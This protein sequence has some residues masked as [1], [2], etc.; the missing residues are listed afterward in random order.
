MTTLN[1]INEALGEF[2]QQYALAKE[3][4]KRVINMVKT[5]DTHI[6]FAPSTDNKFKMVQIEID[7]SE[8]DKD[9]KYLID[10]RPT[11][12]VFDGVNDDTVAL[13]F[14]IARNDVLKQTYDKLEQTLYHIAAHELNHGYVVLAQSKY[15]ERGGKDIITPLP[16]WYNTCIIFLQNYKH[17]DIAYQF[18]QGLYACYEKEIKAIVSETS[19]QI[20]NY[21]EKLGK[22][23][24]ESFI[25]ALENSESFQ[26]YYTILH[27]ILPNVDENKS[28]I[29]KCLDFWG[30]DIN[31]KIF[32]ELLR[33]MKQRASVALHYTQKNA[34]LY[35]HR[36]IQREK[37][38][39]FK[40][41]PLK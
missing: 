32:N 14:F 27:K 8:D 13:K 10:V 2:P 23:D 38:D 26:R 9:F 24:R 39:W 6:E 17:N 36:F 30:F 41:H 12:G 21:L 35:Y 40:T 22:N 15:N 7:Y 1:V 33:F 28:K 20:E 25:E 37:T 5:H 3:I 16:D 31:E 19:P 29:I 34:M 4:A 18:V 11:S